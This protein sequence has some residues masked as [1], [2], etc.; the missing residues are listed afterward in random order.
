MKILFTILM[1]L[2]V[3]GCA[4][5]SPMVATPTGDGKYWVLLAPLVY[6]HL[7]TGDIYK[8]PRGFVTDLASVPRLFWTAFPPCGK[9]TSAAVVHDYLYWNQA[10]GCDRECAD[11]ILLIA[12]EESG[13]GYITRKAIYRAVRTG[14]R[15]AWNSNK[16]QKASGAIRVIPEEFMNFE[17]YESWEQIQNR[18]KSRKASN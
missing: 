18:I 12:M 7:E 5:K 1:I 17:V 10:N 15:F 11:D 2:T 13:V 4:M 14:G 9:Y 3:A 6:E 16:E 8:I